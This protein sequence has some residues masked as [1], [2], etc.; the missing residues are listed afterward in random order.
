[1]FAN[2]LIAKYPKDFWNKFRSINN[3]NFI[4]ENAVQKFKER[5]NDE[6]EKCP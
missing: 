5:L 6:R 1:L 4:G 3:F 2:A